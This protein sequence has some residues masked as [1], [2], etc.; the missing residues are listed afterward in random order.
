MYLSDVESD[1]KHSSDFQKSR[2][3]R[4]GWTLQELLA[5]NT[6]EFYNWSWCR[7]GCVAKRGLPILVLIDK[8]LLSEIELITR[9]P[10]TILLGRQ[11]LNPVSIAVRMSWASARQTTRIEDM[12]YSLLGIFDIAMPMLYGE[13]TKAFIR[14]QEEIIKNED[15][16]SILAWGLRG[17]VVGGASCFASSPVEFAGCCDF[18]EYTSE[19]T[20]PGHVAI[21]N[22]GLNMEMSIVQLATGDYIGRLIESS[23]QAW[24]KSTISRINTDRS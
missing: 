4:R 1:Q 13:G 23:V 10:T 8:G 24:Q 15:D 22:K 3:F 12:A 17:T 2:W 20:R 16:L 19:N 6:L 14:L 21:T 5:P 18:D 7:L 11:S 9:I